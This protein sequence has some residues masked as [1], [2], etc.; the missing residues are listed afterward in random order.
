MKTLFG[1]ELLNEFARLLNSAKNRI[2]IC[3]PYVGSLKFI[4]TISN[5]KINSSKVEKK[6]IT[7]IKEVSKLNFKFFKR[8][9]KTGELRTLTGVHAKIYIIDNKCLVTSANLTETAFYR[10]HEIGIFLN[11]E[12][13]KESISTYE[14]FWKKSIKIKR[15]ELKETKD[16]KKEKSKDENYGFKLPK[17]W[18]I[19]QKKKLPQFWLKPIG[20][21]EN[22][23]TENQKFSDLEVELHF[24]VNPKAIRVNDIII[25]YGIGAKRILTIY[26]VKTI[27]AKFTENEQ[28]EEWMK[29]WSYYLTGQNLTPDFGKV[30]MKKSLY[31]SNLISEY[32]ENNPTEFIT[33]NKSKGLGA[34][35]FKKDKIRLESDFASFIMNKIEQ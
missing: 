15:I 29:R 25:A 10:R 31:A 26:K 34:L 20:V 19:S 35:N 13:S 8:I 2:W 28:S 4:E 33:H 32:L 3:S 11:E 16:K 18:N 22:P 9:I 5:N 24:A 12:E 14:N 1:N 27:G 17:I 23:I 30:W 21:S 6:F 7:D